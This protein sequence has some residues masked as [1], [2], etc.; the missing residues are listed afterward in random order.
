MSPMISVHPFRVFGSIQDHHSFYGPV[1]LSRGRDRVP[2]TVFKNILGAEG[3]THAVNPDRQQY[4][5]FKY[6]LWCPCKS[7]NKQ[8]S[9]KH[10]RPLPN[11]LPG[12]EPLRGEW[13]APSIISKHNPDIIYH[14]MQYVM[15][16]RDKGDT[17]EFISPDLSYND[18][19]KKR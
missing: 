16:S 2:A 7:R 6:I 18:P 8:L 1:D 3:S 10:K 5:L 15:M 14:G 13:V 17:W 4:N 19:G 9:A 12:E 11:R